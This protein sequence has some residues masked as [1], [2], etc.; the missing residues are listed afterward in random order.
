MFDELDV[1]KSSG[2]RKAV[3]AGADLGNELFVFDEASKVVLLHD[4]FGDGSCGVVGI[5][6]LSGGCKR[7]D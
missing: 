4:I 6:V 1:C 2:L 3:H 7:R 5:F